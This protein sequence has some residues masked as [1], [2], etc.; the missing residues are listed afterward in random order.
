MSADRLSLRSELRAAEGL[1]PEKNKRVILPKK[2]VPEKSRETE[3]H[4]AAAEVFESLILFF[5]ENSAKV[6][7]S[8]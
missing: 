3:K 2:V 5:H 7:F 8:L 6:L 4:L 1:R